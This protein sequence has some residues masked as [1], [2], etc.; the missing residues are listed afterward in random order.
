M[1]AALAEFQ[2][3]RREHAFARERLEVAEIELVDAVEEVARASAPEKFAG[4]TP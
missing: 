3:A 2:Q 4:A 1:R